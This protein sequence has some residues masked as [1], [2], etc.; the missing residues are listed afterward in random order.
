MLKAG[1]KVGAVVHVVQVFVHLVLDAGIHAHDLQGHVQVLSV[2]QAQISHVKLKAVPV[3]ATQQQ[4]GCYFGGAMAV[5]LGQVEKVGQRSA[6]RDGGGVA[7]GAGLR[8][9][10]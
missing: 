3:V 8:G 6:W 7:H 1:A 5:A 10:G 4:A 2:Q 9:G